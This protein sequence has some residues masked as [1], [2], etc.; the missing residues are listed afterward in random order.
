MKKII[1]ASLT[2]VVFLSS[3]I[4]SHNGTVSS[5]PLLHVSDKYVDISSGFS[6][7]LFVFGIGNTSKQELIN[8]AKK[9]LYTRR[10]LQKGE[11][12]S[13]FTTDINKKWIFFIAQKIVVSVSADV[14]VTG[15]TS[16][17]GFGNAFSKKIMPFVPAPNKGAVS[18]DFNGNV[19][20]NGDSVYYSYNSKNYNLYTVSALDKESTILISSDPFYKNILVSLKQNYF[21]I[22]ND[23]G[24]P[25]KINGKV[26]IAV[27]DSFTDKF[28]DEE[29]FVM[30][31]AANNALIKTSSGFHIVPI[32]KLKKL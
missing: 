23:F 3:C 22:K 18:R 13:N 15:D 32:D 1:F 27:L 2:L 24:N 28:V 16:S 17:F 19:I 7:S 20:V 10:P 11:Y 5:G 6:S 4:T 31:Y 29:G 12:Y 21:F 8:D 14:L 9:N 26:S 30:G 25:I